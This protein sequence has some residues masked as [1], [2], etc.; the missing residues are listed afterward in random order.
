MRCFSAPDRKDAA[1]VASMMRRGVILLFTVVVVGLALASLQVGHAASNGFPIVSGRLVGANGLPIVGHI[2]LYVSMPVARPGQTVQPPFLGDAPTDSKGSFSIASNKPQFVPF[3][4]SADQNRAALAAIRANGDWGNIDLI[5]SDGKLVLYRSLA[6][7]VI[8]GARTGFA[9][10]TGTLDIGDVTIAPVSAGVVKASPRTTGS[11]ARINPGPTCVETVAAVGATVKAATVIGELY[12]A[13]DS[14]ESFIY[15]QQASSDIDVGFSGGLG[16]GSLSG[17]VHV[18]NSLG[19]SEQWTSATDNRRQLLANFDYQRFQHRTIGACGAS[20]FTTVSA[21]RW[22]VG[23][24]DGNPA[25]DPSH[26]CTAGAYATP[27][28]RDS[29]PRGRAH[30]FTRTANRAV[31]YGAAVSVFG[32]TLGASSG[33]STSVTLQWA[34]GTKHATYYACGSDN[35]PIRAHRVFTGF[36]G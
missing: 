34:A 6:R 17:D 19:S 27:A 10:A 3:G 22:D 36:S 31:R 33:Y 25:H 11:A 1:A 30:G 4:L 21:V 28:R 15:G 9:S 20:T 12:A 35:D 16:S 32:F 14:T 18:G 2:W 8:A 7:R 13:G 23:Q 29:F 24:A 5:A 26:G